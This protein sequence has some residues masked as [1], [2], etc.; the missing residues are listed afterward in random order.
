MT[1]KVNARRVFPTGQAPNPTISPGAFQQ[2]FQ[3]QKQLGAE[4]KELARVLDKI[5]RTE[6]DSQFATARMLINNELDNFQIRLQ[7]NSEP[8]TYQPELDQTIKT[9]DSEQFIGKNKRGAAQTRSWIKLNTRIWKK[10][11][12]IAAEEKTIAIAQ[13]AYITNTDAAIKGLD[14]PEALRLIDEAETNGIIQPDKAAKDRLELPA[15]IDEEVVFANIRAGLFDEAEKAVS[16]SKNIGQKE[17]H[18]LEQTINREREK[19]EAKDSVEEQIRQSASRQEYVDMV[20]GQDF[21]N[22][23]GYFRTN[24]LTPEENNKTISTYN[25]HIKSLQDGTSSP[26][27]IDD[28]NI[29]DALRIRINTATGKEKVTDKELYSF[30]GDGLSTSTYNKLLGMVSNDK[31][32]LKRPTAARSQAVLARTRTQMISEDKENAVNINLSFLKKQDELDNY[33]TSIA[34]DQDFDKKVRDFTASLIEPE[35]DRVTLNWFSR[36]MRREKK[37]LTKEGAGQVEDKNEFTGLILSEQE[38]LVRKKIK[39]LKEQPVWETLTEAEKKSA[40]ERFKRGETVQS[41]VD[42]LNG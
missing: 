4:T 19:A 27:D 2:E 28:N 36:L 3:A 37:F 1:I 41:I 30:Y 18:S 11:T 33:I 26:Y 10:T 12:A 15:K 32:P 42:L 13:G 25:K 34:G 20:K 24:N 29:V 6:G 7:D 38:A 39:V 8:S 14:E 22:I 21:T 40:K 9:F 17:K 5:D 23:E 35:I 16:A 31:D